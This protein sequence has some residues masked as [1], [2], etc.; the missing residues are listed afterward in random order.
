MILRTPT[1]SESPIWKTLFFRQK[2]TPFYIA[3]LN[4]QRTKTFS[5]SRVLRAV[6]YHFLQFVIRWQANRNYLANEDGSN[7]RG[8]MSV[9]SQLN[10]F[11]PERG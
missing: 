9:R 8:S 7:K 3:P 2:T 10:K 6:S 1:K 4:Y 11:S 5:N